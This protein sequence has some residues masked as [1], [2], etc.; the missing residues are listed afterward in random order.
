MT[1]PI[2]LTGKRF[3]RLT[4]L[5]KAPSRPGHA[6]WWCRCDC[7]AEIDVRAQN[8]RNGNT[9]SCGCHKKEVQRQRCIDR[10]IH[11]HGRRAKR[12]R[13]YIAWLNMV[14]RCTN[15]ESNAFHNYGARGIVV[16]ERWLI[17]ANFLADMGE[18]P[19]R[20]TLDRI[21][22]NG[23]YEPGNCKWAT[24]KEQ[25][26]NMRRNRMLEFNGERLTLAQWAERLG[27]NPVS[28]SGRLEGGWP[29]AEALTTPALP[30]KRPKPS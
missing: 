22:V 2:D 18:A 16:C 17:F 1:T 27:I 19:P 13:A 23:N 30:G 26:N 7:G 14:Q 21:D 6:Q 28:L 11:G 29:L 12:S 4:V 15:P 20:L 25:A 24:R 5:R 10:T 9:K 8:L 3:A